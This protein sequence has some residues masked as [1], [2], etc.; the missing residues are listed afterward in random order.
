VTDVKRHTVSKTEMETNF[1]LYFQW[2]IFCTELEQFVLL[3]LSVLMS[4]PRTSMT[5]G[6]VDISS[7]LKIS[8]L[9]S[10]NNKYGGQ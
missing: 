3:F 4:A 2:D 6:N 7:V 8:L 1:K 10:Y 5:S 9:S